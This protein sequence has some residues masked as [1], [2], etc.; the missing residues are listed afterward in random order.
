MDTDICYLDISEADQR[1]PVYRIISLDRLYEMF[2]NKTNTLVMP[3]R[4]DD[5]FENSILGLKAQL[6]SGAVVEFGQRYIFYGQSW[7]RIYNTDAMWRIYSSDKNSV[8]IKT[9]IHKLV[10]PLA[11]YALGLVFI[12]KVRYFTAD[13]LFR[14]AKKVF[15]DTEEP[16]IRLLARTLLVK[17]KAFSHEQEVRLLYVDPGASNRNLNRQVPIDFFQYKIDPHAMIEKMFLDPRLSEEE[18]SHLVEVIRNR[19]RFRGSISRSSLYE[20]PPNLTVRLGAAYE[21]L[22]RSQERVS[23]SRGY[24]TV[25]LRS[26]IPQIMLPYSPHPS[27]I[28][29]KRKKS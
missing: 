19:T 12:G 2:E 20:A 6:P 14:W 11:I 8:C 22:P 13:G 3:H 29:A 16:D 25:K 23:Y 15:L 26:E 10:D 7:T 17:R 1:L 18:T 9:R 27:Q 28:P 24:K 21:S 4:W 5:P